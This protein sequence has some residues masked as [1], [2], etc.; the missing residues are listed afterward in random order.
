MSFTAYSAVAHCTVAELDSTRTA[1]LAVYDYLVN[2]P[3]EIPGGL[4]DD[5]DAIEEIERYLAFEGLPGQLT[6]SYDTESEFGNHDPA[7]FAFLSNHFA[8][9]QTSPYMEV[10][11]SSFDS[12]AGTD[13]GTDYYDRQGHQIDIHALL[14]SQL[15]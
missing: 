9:L 2:H 12:R 13:G 10:A 7:V 1:A 11:W 14:T 15:S 4:S 8:C 3:D 5:E 6:I